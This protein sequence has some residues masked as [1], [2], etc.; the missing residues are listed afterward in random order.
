MGS[1]R[2]KRNDHLRP[3][4]KCI[5][6]SGKFHTCMVMQETDNSYLIRHLVSEELG[7]LLFSTSH[8]KR[9][10]TLKLKEQIATVNIHNNHNYETK[11]EDL[12]SMKIESFAR[13]TKCNVVHPISTLD[14]NS[15]HWMYWSCPDCQNKTE[16]ENFEILFKYNVNAPEI[17]KKETVKESKITN[18]CPNCGC[19]DNKME[20]KVN[21]IIHCQSCGIYYIGG[22]IPEEKTEKKPKYIHRGEPSEFLKCNHCGKV[23]EEGEEFWYMG[24]PNFYLCDKCYQRRFLTPGDHLREGIKRKEVNR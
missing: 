16:R 17:Q 4:H 24:S 3:I 12:K 10:S 19:K 14:N 20:D 18:N 2:Y 23:E 21:K 11:L 9:K 15:F 7:W 8:W 1:G 22:H 13:C 5:S 6:D